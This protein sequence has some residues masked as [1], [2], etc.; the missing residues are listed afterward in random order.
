MTYR[1]EGV[2]PKN[3]SKPNRASFRLS[4]LHT[5]IIERIAEKQGGLTQTRVVE[6]ALERLWE[7]FQKSEKKLAKPS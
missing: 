2:M 3:V 6:W 1:K 4:R 5:N 7:D